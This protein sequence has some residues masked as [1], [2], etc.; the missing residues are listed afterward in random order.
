MNWE[1]LTSEDFKAAV[2]E[3]GVCIVAFGVVERHGDHLPLGTDYLNG[4]RLA[5]LAAE[6]EKAVVFP[7]FYFGQIY[8]AR[9]FPGTITIQPALLIELIQGVF[10]EI[11]RNG[12]KKIIILNAH[13]GND[14][15]LKF[16]VQAQLWEEKP[17][18]IYWYQPGCPARTAFYREIC[19]SGLH[20]H[21]CECETSISLFH[22]GELVKTDRI[23][24]ETYYPKKR[25][26]H[27][28]KNFSALSWY[29]N[30]PEHYV[31]NANYATYEKGEALVRKETEF[32]AQFIAD[33]K[34]DQVLP[35]LSNEFYSCN[36]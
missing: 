19:E 4:H 17:Y 22:H 26:G 34:T 18:V 13:G 7:P 28:P 15:L 31:G 36:F 24:E 35:V 30:Y 8:E 23:P 21:A 12:F 27:L 32:L 9:C 20:G 14:G 33:V 10:D 29:S 3:T 25:L 5:T 2:I 11:G 6:K 1:K 16:I